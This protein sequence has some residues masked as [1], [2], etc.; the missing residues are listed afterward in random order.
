LGELAPEREASLVLATRPVR[1]PHERDH[2][3]CMRNPG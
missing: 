2:G 1:Y 3:S